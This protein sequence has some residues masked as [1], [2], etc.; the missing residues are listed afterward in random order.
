MTPTAFDWIA[1]LG[2][3]PTQVLD[4]LQSV[5]PLGIPVFATLAIVTIGLSVFRKFGI[6]K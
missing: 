4:G 6:R 3:L 2:T 5:I 1:V